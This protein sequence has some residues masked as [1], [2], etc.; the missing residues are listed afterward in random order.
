MT[1][2]SAPGHYPGSLPPDQPTLRG[3]LVDLAQQL[4]ATGLRW[5]VMGGIGSA[6]HARP[7]PTDDID[8]LIHP[9]DADD[10]LEL[11]ASHGYEVERTD[12]RWLYKAYRKGV[13]IDLVFRSSGEVYLDEQM[14]AHATRRQFHGIE[15]PTVAAE[16]LLVIKALTAA[17]HT[18]HH[19][20]DALAIISLSDLDWDYLVE[21]AR[22]CG[23]RRVLSLLLYAE[24]LD[25][26]VPPW[27]VTTLFAAVHPAAGAAP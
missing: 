26:T 16:D 20:Y 9:E 15:I 2:V 14:L 3:V 8:L 5:L 18:A 21:R 17:E 24:S 12:P 27:A 7:R 13:L 25:L 6:A 10:L 11:L 19:W 23:P 4:G 22:R 1:G